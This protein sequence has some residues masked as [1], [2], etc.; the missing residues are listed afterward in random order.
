MQR[1]LSV[2]LCLSLALAGCKAKELADKAA[3]SKDL[4]KRGTTD[5]MKEVANDSYDPPQDGRLAEAQIQMYLKVRE[6]EKKIAEVAKAELKQHAENADKKGDKSIGGFMEGMKALGSAADLMTADIRAAKDLGYNTQEYLWVKQQILAA[7]T[8]QMAEQFSNAMAANFDKAYTEAKKAHDEA[9]DEQTKKLYADVLAGYDKSKQEM[10]AQKQEVD[11]AAA[12]NRQ[13]LS[14]YENALNAY[15][16]EL[17]KYEDKPGEVNKA[18]DEMQ[19][20]LAE[21]QK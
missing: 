7:S 21:Q 18:M 11:P 16:H 15:A 6:H 9:K 13:L 14:K 5:L 19:K 10:T 3:I 8:A 12:Y 2:L 1:S 20:K 4:D 17:S